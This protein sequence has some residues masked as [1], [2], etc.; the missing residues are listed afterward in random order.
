MGI[1]GLMQLTPFEAL[2]ISY[3]L[4]LFFL[5]SIQKTFAISQLKLVAFFVVSFLN[6]IG[7]IMDVPFDGVGHGLHLQACRSTS[8]NPLARICKPDSFRMPS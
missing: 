5:D 3:A 6:F 2:W 4:V 8:A 7:F 1:H